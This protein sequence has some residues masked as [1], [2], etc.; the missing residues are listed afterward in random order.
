MTYRI[1]GAIDVGSY[2]VNLKIYELSMKDG[3]RLLNHVRHRLDLGSDTYATGKIGTELVDELCQVLLDFKRIMKDYGVQ[4]YRA[5]ATSAIRE[6]HNT[7]ILLDRIY[8]KTGIHI[9]V[10]ANS[11]QR[12]LGYKSIASNENAFQNII[13]KGTAIVDVGGGSVQIS[14]FDKD[15]LVTTQNIRMGSL[16]LRE[17]LADVAERTVRYAAV[18]EELLDNELR[19]Y[20]KLYKC[21]GNVAFKTCAICKAEIV[22]KRFLRSHNLFPPFHREIPLQVKAA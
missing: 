11:E 21:Y 2:E 17:R 19:T 9:E 14:L 4:E 16:R 5:C 22:F 10:L 6:T 18:V 20:K 1:F 15:N 12:Y 13:E 8:L 7:L 3:I